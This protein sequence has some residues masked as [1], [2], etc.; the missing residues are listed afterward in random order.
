MSRGEEVW[1]RQSLGK[2]KS[3]WIQAG[4]WLEAWFEILWGE[5]NVLFSTFLG[6]AG[7]SPEARKEPITLQPGFVFI[8]R[9]I[10]WDPVDTA[11]PQVVHSP[12]QHK[13]IKHYPVLAMTHLC[14]LPAVL[15]A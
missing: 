7:L 3:R 10:Q 6:G 11:S 2:G 5:V 8:Q 13:S 12:M 1:A 14:S 9:L 15:G 4:F